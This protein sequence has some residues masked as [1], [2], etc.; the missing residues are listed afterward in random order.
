MGREARHPDKQGSRKPRCLDGMI[1]WLHEGSCDPEVTVKVCYAFF[2]R[3]LRPL[4]VGS[5]VRL[6]IV[7][8]SDHR[9][10]NWFKYVESAMCLGFNTIE[11]MLEAEI[12]WHHRL[13]PLHARKHRSSLG[14]LRE[15]MDV[16]FRCCSC[17]W[18]ERFQPRLKLYYRNTIQE[19]LT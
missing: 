6:G 9:Y 7:R 13:G 4:Y 17:G 10:K 14:H 2:G 11:E 12:I 18:T 15:D 3:G 19:L 5:S 8:M 1:S 16:K